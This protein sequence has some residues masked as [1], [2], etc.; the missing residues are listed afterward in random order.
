MEK[1]PLELFSNKCD[2]ANTEEIEYN[3]EENLIESIK[4]FK[5]IFEHAPQSDPMLLH[6]LIQCY[7][8]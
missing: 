7:N 8:F 3:F 5:Q 1:T 4:K 2:K 6:N